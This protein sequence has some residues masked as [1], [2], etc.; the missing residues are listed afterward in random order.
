ME[1]KKLF[2]KIGIEQAESLSVYIGLTVH[3]ESIY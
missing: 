2:Q 3:F 1:G